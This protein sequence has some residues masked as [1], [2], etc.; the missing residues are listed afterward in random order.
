[1]RGGVAPLSRRLG[2]FMSGPFISVPSTVTIPEDAP[3]T[4]I[5]PTAVVSDASGSP[6]D[7]LDVSITAPSADDVLGV[8]EDGGA[9][10]INLDT[11][12]SEVLYNGLTI[13]TYTRVS[14]SLLTFNF[15]G[16]ESE[17]AEQKQEQQNTFFDGSQTPD[18]TDRT[19]H[20]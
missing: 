4:I 7:T 1:M 16:S 18:T 14:D 12:T 6:F 15:N 19:I 2:V 9:N 3:A 13:G 11:N 8:E 20:F 5:S 10:E 17:A